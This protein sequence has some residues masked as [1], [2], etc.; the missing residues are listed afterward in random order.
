LPWRRG[1]AVSSLPTTE[2]I[3]AT[4]REI[5][6][7]QGIGWKLFK[8]KKS[9]VYTEAR[10]YVL[11][12]GVTPRLKKS[13]E[14]NNS[15]DISSSSNVIT[16]DNNDNKNRFAP[17]PA[18]AAFKKQKRGFSS[19]FLLDAP[20]EVNWSLQQS[21]DRKTGGSSPTKS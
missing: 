18:R 1:L 10:L 20:A 8:L 2:G 7:R 13:D 14:I 3:G 19:T 11:K 9:T 15:N 16:N 21:L 6:S 12:A 17:S 5:V 4:G